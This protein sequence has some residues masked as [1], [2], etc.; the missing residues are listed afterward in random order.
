MIFSSF[1]KSVRKKTKNFDNFYPFYRIENDMKLFWLLVVVYIATFEV[2]S[3]LA[4]RFCDCDHPDNICIH[5]CPA[6]VNHK[7]AGGK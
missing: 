3:L 6:P 7:P 2:M 5:L 1:A 4:D